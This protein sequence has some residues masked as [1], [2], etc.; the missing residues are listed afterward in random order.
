MN[1][2]PLL[3]PIYY[4]VLLSFRLWKFLLFLPK[5]SFFCLWNV[6]S[7]LGPL[8]SSHFLL[9]VFPLPSYFNFGH[10]ISSTFELFPNLIPIVHCLQVNWMMP[11][12]DLSKIQPTFFSPSKSNLLPFTYVHESH[13]TSPS[14]QVQNLGISSSYMEKT[15]ICRWQYLARHGKKMMN[16]TCPASTDSSQKSGH[17]FPFR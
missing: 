12:V 7:G 6:E 3:P 16:G 13:C 17:F 8:L 11:Y 10:Y 2:S 15:L 4:L 1:L 9:C 5:F 14:Y